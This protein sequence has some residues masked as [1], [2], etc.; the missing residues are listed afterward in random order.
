MDGSH[1]QLIRAP[2]DS[3]QQCHL[4]SKVVFTSC[5]AT[6]I[7]FAATTTL[8][9][10]SIIRHMVKLILSCL[11]TVTGQVEGT[12]LVRSLAL[13][14]RAKTIC[15]RYRHRCPVDGTLWLRTLHVPRHPGRDRKRG[16]NP[17]DEQQYDSALLVMF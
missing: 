9:L 17:D 11:P 13:T 10:K 5:A 2:L 7:N 14:D 3:V 6:I 4:W 15:P 1:V 8:V 16:G 12:I